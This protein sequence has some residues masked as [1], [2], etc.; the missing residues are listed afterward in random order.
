MR[1]SRTI[2][3]IA[4]CCHLLWTVA[5]AFCLCS[6]VGR[7]SKAV[8]TSHL[9]RVDLTATAATD[10]LHFG[11][12][13]T[14]EIVERQFVV[15]NSGLSP[16]LLL[17][18]ETSCGCLELEYPREPIVAGEERVVTMRFY[19]LGYTYFIPRA[20]Y[21]RTSLSPEGRCLIVTADME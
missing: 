10:T 7:G 19:S 12:V 15:C 1:A 3:I 9:Q 8:D 20:F 6:C 18:T 21:L 2:P 17:G 16:V 5:F 4:K 14:G 13:R 11:S